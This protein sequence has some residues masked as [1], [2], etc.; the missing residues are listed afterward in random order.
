MR[1][2][3]FAVLI[4]F[5]PAF[6]MAEQAR[7]IEIVDVPTANTLTKGEVRGDFKFYPGG[8][9]LNRIYVGVF[10]RFMIGGAERI[11]NIIGSDDITAH[12]PWFLTKLRV[13]DDN[14][15]VPAIALGYEG[16]TYFDIPYSKG[17]FLS[18]TKEIKLGPVFSQLTGTIYN[19]NEFKNFGKKLDAGAG[20]AFAIT[21]EFTVGAEYDGIFGA[22]Y[23][24]DFNTT[25]GYF[26]DPI[27]IDLGMKF[28]LWSDKEYFSRILRV[29]YVAY[30]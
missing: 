24:R 20:I 5:L 10:D 13:T 23:H 4:L 29:I 21:K 1:K 28:G 17:L 15:A 14:D 19:D 25:V 27:E 6:V 16:E 11:D 12:I 7:N 2:T 18:I 3:F 9:I 22:A 30:F 26:F 8:G